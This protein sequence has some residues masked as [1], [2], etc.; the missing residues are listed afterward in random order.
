MAH[1]F[2]QVVARSAPG[3]ITHKR[4]S[5]RKKMQRYENLPRPGSCGLSCTAI[6]VVYEYL[7]PPER[8]KLEHTFAEWSMGDIRSGF[9]S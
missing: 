2:L 1:V 8:A 9:R 5:V 3:E 4:Q 6:N 7:M